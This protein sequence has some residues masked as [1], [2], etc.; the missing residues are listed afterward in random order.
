[1]GIFLNKTQGAESHWV[2]SDAFGEIGVTPDGMNSQIDIVLEQEEAMG[3]IARLRL[4]LDEAVSREDYE[5]AAQ[6]R[7]MLAPLVGSAD[8][9]ND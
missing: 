8:K 3:N 9:E 7:D 2:A 1:M 5:R 6:L 4:E